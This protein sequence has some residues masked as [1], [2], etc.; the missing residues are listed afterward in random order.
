MSK[1][2][3]FHNF[4]L[5]QAVKT[6]DIQYII[7]FEKRCLVSMYSAL[8]Y[9]RKCPLSIAGRGHLYVQRFSLNLN[10]K[11][12]GSLRRFRITFHLCISTDSRQHAA[13]RH[14][15]HRECSWS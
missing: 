6:E 9:I 14:L 5:L 13:E 12:G 2:R 10:T 1:S 3:Y 4:D 8:R 11:T 7:K 15:P